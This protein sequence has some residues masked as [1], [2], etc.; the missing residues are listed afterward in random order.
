MTLIGIPIIGREFLASNGKTIKAGPGLGEETMDLQADWILQTGISKPTQ[1]VIICMMGSRP[2]K[3]TTH[4]A[5][6]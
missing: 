1:S 2:I 3:A 4:I 5:L 6:M